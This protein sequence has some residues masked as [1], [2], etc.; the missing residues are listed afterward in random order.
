[1]S[2]KKLESNYTK[3]FAIIKK[4]IAL[5]AAMR[6]YSINPLGELTLESIAVY[7]I[8]IIRKEIDNYCILHNL[9]IYDYKILSSGETLVCICPA[10]KIKHKNAHRVCL[11]IDP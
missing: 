5:S 10:S 11:I 1:M 4:A 2:E 8:G 7:A 6:D 3:S 9:N